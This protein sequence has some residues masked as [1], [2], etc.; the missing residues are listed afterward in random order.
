MSNTPEPSH[1]VIGAAIEVHRRMGPG[2]LESIYRSCLVLELQLRGHAVA[3]ERE[4][5]VHY[6]GRRLECGFRIDLV[7]DEKLIVEVKAV[8]ALEPVHSAQVLTYMRLTG[9]RHGLLI[10][11]NVQLLKDGIKRHIDSKDAENR[12]RQE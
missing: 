3:T 7:V 9:L 5:P 6:R 10:N 11:F 1:S 2:L 12:K 8:R 4:V